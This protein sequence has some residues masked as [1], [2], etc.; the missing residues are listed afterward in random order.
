MTRWDSLLLVELG[1]DKA[2]VLLNALLE[3]RFLPQCAFLLELF[4]Q[5][6]FL[7]LLLKL[8]LHLVPLLLLFALNNV[9]LV[10][11]AENAALLL[12]GDIKATLNNA[13]TIHDRREVLLRLH[14]RVVRCC[15]AIAL[16]IGRGLVWRNGI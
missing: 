2:K 10:S 6:L 3:R 16:L 14:R 7:D 11:A 9:F 13:A 12:E 1:P 5:G 15:R 8:I 4:F